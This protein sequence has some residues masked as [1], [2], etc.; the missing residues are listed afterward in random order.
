MEHNN[1]ME[2]V[3]VSKLLTGIVPNTRMHPNTVE[4]A[5]M[6]AKQVTYD[7]FIHL[8]YFSV[9]LEVWPEPDI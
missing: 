7:W 6:L 5:E 2:W 1:S 8:K 3:V 4:T 9:S